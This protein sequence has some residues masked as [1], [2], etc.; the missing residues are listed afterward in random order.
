MATLNS[1]TW[2]LVI[3]YSET[4]SSGHHMIQRIYGKIKTSNPTDN[5][6][7]VNFK[8]VCCIDYNSTGIYNDYHHSRQFSAPNA[9]PSFS[10]TFALGKYTTANV[11]KT[12]ATWDMTFTHNADGTYSEIATM[13]TSGY[14]TTGIIRTENITLPTYPK[15]HA[16][17]VHNGTSYRSGVLYVWKGVGWIKPNITT[18]GIYVWN[19][20]EW[21]LGTLRG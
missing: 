6:T 1:S 4:V 13:K 15:N 17:Y 9:S 10:D 19:G 21:V 20:S 7:L 12:L 18:Q 11:E 14:N 2:T 16:V 3:E 8:W 5:T